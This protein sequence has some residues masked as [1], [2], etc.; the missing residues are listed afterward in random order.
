VGVQDLNSDDLERWSALAERAVE[1]NPF[2]EPDF[3]DLA[4]RHFDGFART[5]LL[6][7]SEDSAW[8]AMVPVVGVG[9]PKIPPRRSGM[10]NGF[11]TMISGL[12]TPLVD[13]DHVEEA[14]GAL[15]DG[16]RREAQGGGLPGILFLQRVDE[17]GPVAAAL[18]RASAVRGMPVFSKESWERG[19]VTRTGHWEQPVSKERRR[20]NA[21]RR[22]ML[23]RDAELEVSLVDRTHDPAAAEEFLKMEASGWKGEGTGTA[24]AREPAKI[25]WF[26]EW[27]DSW[28]R[29]GR[30]TL[31]AVNVGDTS[32][33]MQYFLR[34]GEGMFLFR[35]AY[36][37]DYAKYGPGALMLEYGMAAQFEQ[38]DATWLDSN[39]D[40]DNGFLLEMLPE[41]RTIATLLIGTGGAVDRT[42][43][44]TMPIMTRGVAELRRVRLGLSRL[45][46]SGSSSAGDHAPEGSG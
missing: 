4:A 12:S 29:A 27:V 43:V 15:L 21:R 45:R 37:A 28:T 34:A 40:P 24:M 10:T 46:H 19:L 31:L 30:V 20:Q 7:A 3:L 39:T 18:R 9:H 38:S 11:P 8:R 2:F 13:R 42:A 32:I 41:R 26:H 14:T 5:R 33:A 36:D 17:Q 35:T 44:S 6:I 23:E 1:P 25:A 16:L 22:R